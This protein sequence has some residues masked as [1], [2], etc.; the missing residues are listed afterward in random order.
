[1]GDTNGG[2]LFKLND[3]NTWR[4]PDARDEFEVEKKK[5]KI[6]RIVMEEW[7]QMVMPGKNKPKRIP[8]KKYPFRLVKSTVPA[9]TH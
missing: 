5:G 9:W 7:R 8:M 4:P 6:Y 1:M 2:A 3:A